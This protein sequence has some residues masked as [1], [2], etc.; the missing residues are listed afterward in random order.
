MGMSKEKLKKAGD[1]DYVPGAPL[2]E[3]YCGS[4]MWCFHLEGRPATDFRHEGKGANS[5]VPKQTRAYQEKV[6]MVAKRER[7]K[8]WPLDAIVRLE[9][10]FFYPTLVMPDLSNPQKVI[11]D[12]LEGIVYENDKQ[13]WRGE[14]RKRLNPDADEPSIIVK[15]KI[16]DRLTREVN[17]YRER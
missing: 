17:E 13:I 9:I 14:Q 1:G 10:K 6:A 5:W 11:E 12:A 2:I 4:P 7:P 8:G 15:V 16:L 3:N